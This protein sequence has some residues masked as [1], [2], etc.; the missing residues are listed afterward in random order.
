VVDF[1]PGG[2]PLKNLAQR[3]LETQVQDSRDVPDDDV[4]LL[5]A[6]LLR[7]PLSVTEWCS[8]GHLP[9][10]TNLLLLVDQFEELFRY[11]DY[12]GREEAEAFAALLL[13]SARQKKFPIYVALT[14]RSEYLGACALIDGLA[15]AIS[16]G[17]YLI[18]RMSR[19]QCRAAI[20]GPATVCNFKIEDALTNRLLG[21]PQQS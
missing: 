20:T 5:R 11:Q 4:A 1:R 2:A 19:E 16:V 21:R 9:P 18:P 8:D 15:E 13:E 14:M 6:F 3:L 10:A 17:M 7:G 12:A